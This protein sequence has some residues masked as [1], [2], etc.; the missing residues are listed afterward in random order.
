MN[1]KIDSLRRKAEKEISC[2]NKR[3]LVNLDVLY[4][5]FEKESLARAALLPF[6]AAASRP[7]RL[8]DDAGNSLDEN[9]VIGLGIR[10]KDW[11]KAIELTSAE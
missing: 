11:Q 7:G 5:L 2:G 1:E 9:A 10:V 8:T 3:T 4:C 6:A